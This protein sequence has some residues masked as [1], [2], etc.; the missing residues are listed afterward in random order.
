MDLTE[1][2]EIFSDKISNISL[3]DLTSTKCLSTFFETVLPVCKFCSHLT[4]F[5][6]NAENSCVK[7]SCNLI[8]TVK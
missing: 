4:H 2:L 5:L 6:Q 1:K 7:G 3:S 8:Q